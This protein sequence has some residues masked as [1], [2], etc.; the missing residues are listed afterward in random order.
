[1]RKAPG[2]FCIFLR[3]N[4]YERT[5]HLR[6]LLYHFDGQDLCAQCL[7]N[8]TLF[9]SYCG[10]RIWK[11]ENAGTTDT[12]LCQDCFDDHYACCCRCGAL[13]R[14]TTAYYEESGEF[15]KRPYCLD[16]FHA[17]SLD[18][19]I[20]DYYYKPGPIFQ[21]DGPR[22]FGVERKLDEGGEDPDSAR[23]LLDIANAQYPLIHIKHDGSLDDGLDLVTHPLS[24]DWQ[25]HAM[26]WQEVCRKALALGHR[27]HRT[28]TC[29]LYLHVSRGAFGPGPG[30]CPGSLLR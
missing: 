24:L 30:Y 12:P 1:M 17:R 10:D 6:D 26:P 8:N 15:D 22:F 9:C 14:E 3:R 28:S 18:K 7:D 27:S 4:F 20:H 25:L 19:P 5:A 21:G 13:V 23:A 16:C 2:L 29:G 11:N